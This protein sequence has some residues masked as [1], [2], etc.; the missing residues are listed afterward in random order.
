MSDRSQSPFFVGE[1]R[2]RPAECRLSRDDRTVSVR[3]RV[4]DLLVYLAQRPGEVLSKDTLL[5][6]VGGPTQSV[7]PR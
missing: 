5:N 6:E 3:P 4:M 1:W 7:S 2:V